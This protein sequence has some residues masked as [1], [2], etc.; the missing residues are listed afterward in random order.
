M[1]MSP[2][3]LRP[4]ASGFNPKAIPGLEIWFDASVASSVTLN[5][6][7][8]SQI[9]D[10]SGNNRHLEQPT[11]ANQPAYLANGKNGKNVLDFGAVNGKFMRQT[12]ASAMTKAQPLTFFW[13]LKIPASGAYTASDVSDAAFSGTGRVVL[14]GNVATEIRFEAGVANSTPTTADTWRVITCVY[15]GTSSSRRISTSTATTFS[16]GTNSYSNRLIIGAN[17]GTGGGFRSLIGEL[18]FFSGALTDSQHTAILT[19]LANKW[20]VTLS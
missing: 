18:G 16:A 2:R 12:L 14:Y 15:D 11:A 3:L 6:G 5:G 17:H 19:Y 4:K 1:A 9:D 10:L 7:D 8:V 13:A 20:A